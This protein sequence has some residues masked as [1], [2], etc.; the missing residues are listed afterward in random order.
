VEES[1]GKNGIG[2]KEKYA[3]VLTQYSSSMDNEFVKNKRRVSKKKG[4]F[5]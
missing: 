1:H 3:R 5:N 2:N 4:F